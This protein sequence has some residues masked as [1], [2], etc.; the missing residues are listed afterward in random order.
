FTTTG[1]II[2]GSTKTDE[3][4]IGSVQLISADPKPFDAKY[5]LG[6]GFAEIEARTSDENLNVI[7]DRIIVLFSGVPGI[8]I[9]PTSFDIPNAGQQQ[10]DYT[11]M[12]QN[13]NPLAGGTRISVD[14]A[15]DDAG[16]LGD[17]SFNLPDT[18]SPLWTQFRFI[19][20]DTKPDTTKLV[21]VG[22]SI[23]TEGP[24]GRASVTITGHKR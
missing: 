15:G 5:G 11:V 9:N 6:A 7:T 1:G 17:V 14:V 8:T 21:P 10:F 4:G 12:D 19:L 2:V 23:V 20:Y 16:L 3:Q 13:Q 22:L 24:N 18:Q